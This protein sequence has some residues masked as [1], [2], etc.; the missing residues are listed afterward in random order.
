MPDPTNR[1]QPD[2]SYN[3]AAGTPQEHDAAVA[4]AQT[5]DLPSPAS[6]AAAKPA[7]ASA[8]A[9]TAAATTP[10][11]KWKRRVRRGLYVLGGVLG[12]L[13][14]AWAGL[15]LYYSDERLRVL[16]EEQIGRDLGVRCRIGTLAMYS[17]D[18]SFEVRQL[19][20]EDAQPA[21]AQSAEMFALEKLQLDI[22]FWRSLLRRELVVDLKAEGATVR[23][24]RQ[25]L[26][27]KG[28]DESDRFTTNIHDLLNNLVNLPWKSWLTSF[29]WRLA[30][31][32]ARVERAQ[33]QLN[34]QAGI[35]G[36]C[37]FR[38][39]LL[40]FEREGEHCTLAVSFQSQT[41]AARDGTF[42]LQA[43]ADVSDPLAPSAEQLA[44]LRNL[45]L[46][47]TFTSFDIPYVT[48]YYGVGGRGRAGWQPG[49][50]IDGHI[51]ASAPTMRALTLDIDL[52]TPEAVRVLNDGK[53][54]AGAPQ[55]KLNLAGVID[56]SHEWSVFSPLR[57]RMQAGTLA[58]G[59]LSEWLN[60]NAELRGSLDEALILTT[61]CRLDSRGFA[62]SSIGRVAHLDGVLS[63]V[64]KPSVSLKFEKGRPLKFNLTVSSSDLLFHTAKGDASAPLVVDLSG[65]L[66]LAEDL[67]PLSGDLNLTLDAQTL[68]L[69]SPKPWLF[70]FKD[71]P[72]A[73][74]SL[75]VKADLGAL[76]RNLAK[77]L[78]A[79]GIGVVDETAAGTLGLREDGALEWDLTFNRP[80][81][82]A[83]NLQGSGS[84]APDGAFALQTALTQSAA[85][86]IVFNVKT[87]GRLTPSTFEA[88]F[89][90][91]LSA[92]IDSLYALRKRLQ[93]LFPGS[94]LPPQKL[95]GL[96][97]QA[98]RGRISSSGSGFSLLAGVS[99]QADNVGVIGGGTL[100]Q[101][102][103]ATLAGS[104]Q[105]NHTTAG[106]QLKVMQMDLLTSAGTIKLKNEL[107]DTALFRQNLAGIVTAL[108]AFA[109][110]ANL[111]PVFFTRLS[112]LAGESLPAFLREGQ[113]LQ[114]KAASAGGRG[115]WNVEACRLQT[116]DLSLT[117]Q[118]FTFS[119]DRFT[120]R[121][122]A[123]DSKG[124]LA[125]FSPLSLN[126]TCGPGFWGALPLPAGLRMV[127]TL[128][129]AAAYNPADDRLRLP[130][131]EFAAQREDSA[132]LS[133]LL[134]SADILN[135]SRLLATPDL[136]TVA[137]CLSAGLNVARLDVSVPALQSFADLQHAAS[138]RALQGK[139]LSLR[140]LQLTPLRPAAPAAD[141]SLEFQ[142][143]FK[144]N[145]DMAYYSGDARW[146]LL[147]LGG[148][149]AVAPQAPLRVRV[150]RGYAG[151]AGALD[152]TGTEVRFAA[153]APYVYR[154]QKRVPARLSFSLIRQD[155]GAVALA[156]AELS[157]GPLPVKLGDLS[158][159]DL[160]GGVFRLQLT[161]ADLGAPFNLSIRDILID[162]AANVLKADA[163]TTGID[164]T[165]LGAQ[166]NLPGDARLSGRIG[167]TELHLNDRYQNFLGG[168]AA[169]GSRLGPD[170]RLKL[171][172][173]DLSL[174][175]Q[176]PEGMV[177]AGFALA[178][179]T[180][181]TGSGELVL[182]GL[183]IDKP[184]GFT[185]DDPLTINQIRLRL[186]TRTLLSDSL[187]IDRLDLKGLAATIEVGFKGNNIEAL[188]KN[189]ELLLAGA[190][191]TGAPAGGEAD[192]RRKTL[193]R[194][195]Y[196]DEGSV[197]LTS[198]LLRGKAAIPVA[199]PPLHLQNIGGESSANAFQQVTELLLKSILT[200][201]ASLLKSVGGAAGSVAEGAAGLLGDA[202]SGTAGAVGNVAGGA[203]GL[204]GGIGRTLGRA[205][206]PGDGRK[207]DQ[208]APPEASGDNTQPLP[209]AAMIDLL[210][211][212]GLRPLPGEANTYAAS[213]VRLGEIAQ[214][215]GF[216][217]R[218]MRP[219]VNQPSGSD[220]RT[221]LVRGR[222]MIV[223]SQ[224]R[225][226]QGQVIRGSLDNPDAL[227]SVRVFVPAE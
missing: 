7:V 150:G 95:T 6:A 151:L 197:K 142:L 36:P 26:P 181:D 37:L 192:T 227:C 102:K 200:N 62:N 164:L 120:T 128:S 81:Y 194:D 212:A 162:K 174:A 148:G 28:V 143:A 129:L 189:T 63:G 101:E 215:L 91:Q 147:A 17:A 165:A 61:D 43:Q 195:L 204:L 132:L 160:G 125:A 159:S 149:I 52:S 167:P 133:S 87:N 134:A 145:F 89:D 170:N 25:R 10:G 45:Q 24:N 58:G 158:F 152:L 224:M 66:A 198:K 84:L 106:T 14:L 90:N 68:V 40:A 208:G 42:V 97:R 67:T 59:G 70:Q 188:R 112:A 117:V 18:L 186:D 206:V 38:D 13:V 65:G 168:R 109:I 74:G 64:V 55:M 34:D 173:V 179:G 172:A 139:L 80:E 184:D 107:V 185:A 60:L 83:V 39:I 11:G 114:L 78:E 130:K 201:S 124:A 32:T 19:S 157:G 171:G 100:W 20:M 94:E 127:G 108:P 21:N 54:L 3:P 187:T 138:L 8:A 69:H 154:K 93:G 191:S 116:K 77:P 85:G 213:G 210:T 221:A 35:L 1:P 71:K 190:P 216:D 203:G 88:S 199:L 178:S 217:P 76:G 9:P 131:I 135:A 153:L 123:S 33:V 23:I 207:N 44:F 86:G 98:A 119:A 220:V 176:R 72:S 211:R 166:L 2:A 122:Q 144:S 140:D 27:D 73:A 53:P 225:D 205:V 126:L 113:T 161:K 49:A 51:K 41:P 104:F 226:A 103:Q 209:R 180:A 196:T 92:Q 4:Q 182:E 175:A 110:D 121:L 156:G 46:D 79:L 146:P 57:M 115:D 30:T 223:E 50:P 75:E 111:S 218:Q 15:R 163:A 31:G 222:Y 155:N 48:R 141:G 118:P 193:I 99:A 202:A 214:K 22:H 47:A 5:V 82:G 219:T 136:H 29:D 12:L 169:A 16:A 183:R 137:G 96:V 56:C 177:R 105:L